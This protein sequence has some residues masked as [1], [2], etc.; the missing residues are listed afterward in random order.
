MKRGTG[1][2]LSV[3][4]VVL[5]S[6]GEALP[7]LTASVTISRGL[8]AE[9]REI[10][11]YA[12]SPRRTDNIIL[13]CD[14]LMTSNAQARLAPGDDLIEI[15]DEVSISVDEISGA[16]TLQAVPAGEQ[17]LIFGEA[18]D[19]SSA[20]IGAGCV[21]DVSVAAGQTQEISMTLYE[22]P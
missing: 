15:W 7:T 17:R 8:A 18:Y 5:A 11:L 21:S 13:T 19:A 12:L 20:R 10:R 1:I 4:A 9:T 22:L 14:T 16:V 3:A 2:A 6:C